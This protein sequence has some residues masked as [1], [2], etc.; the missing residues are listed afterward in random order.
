MET[1]MKKVKRIDL[2][3][4]EVDEKNLQKAAQKMGTTKVSKVI[5]NAVENFANQPPELFFC[6]RD[7]IRGIERT[8]NYGLIYLQKFVDEFKAVTG[9]TLTLAEMEVVFEGLGKLY[10]QSIVQEAIRQTVLT[11]SYQKLKAEHPDFT[12]SID[13]VP[14]KDLTA[15][16]EIADQVTNVPEVRIGMRPVIFYHCY[17]INGGILSVILDE[18]EKLKSNYRF[19][20]TSPAE[21]KKLQKVKNLCQA[22]N[23]IM[24]DPEILPD[25]IFTLIY[26]D[27][28]AKRFSPSGAYIKYNLNSTFH[29]H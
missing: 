13:N 21:L 1:S 29:N 15:L 18:V 17:T 24:E 19:Y 6:D 9:L 10:S 4:S 7:S 16:F 3:A 14:E 26:F 8:V 11:K 22:L 28:E 23:E 2:K 27:F 12:F 5:F 20:A 25:K